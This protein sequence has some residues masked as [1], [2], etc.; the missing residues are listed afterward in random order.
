MCIVNRLSKKEVEEYKKGLP[1]EFTAYRAVKTCKDKV[2]ALYQERSEPCTVSPGVHKAGYWPHNRTKADYTPGFHVF[3]E[4]I[5][6]QKA[7]SFLHNEYV[8]PVD[9]TG[10]LIC[11]HI[12]IEEVR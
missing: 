5:E 9:E 11:S 8:M 7:T 3:R 6:A 1:E 12:K 4:E 2:E 10:V